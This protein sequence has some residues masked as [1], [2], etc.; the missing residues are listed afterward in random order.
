MLKI[1]KPA[2]TRIGVFPRLMSLRA[3]TSSRPIFLQCL[4]NGTG[5]RIT[6]KDIQTGGEKL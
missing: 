2:D 1:L 4:K 3:F 5:A 6:I